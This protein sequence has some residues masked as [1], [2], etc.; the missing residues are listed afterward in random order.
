MLI[1]ES[2]RSSTFFNEFSAIMSENP[3]TVVAFLKL[4][5]KQLY[6]PLLRERSE[7]L[8]I[9]RELKSGIFRVLNLT[10]SETPAYNQEV[11]PRNQRKYC[12]IC[13]PKLKR[14]TVSQR[15][16][17]EGH[18]LSRRGGERRI[19]V[20]HTHTFINKLGVFQSRPSHRRSVGR[21]SAIDH[22]KQATTAHSVT[23]KSEISDWPGQSHRYYCSD[24]AGTAILIQRACKRVSDIRLSIQLCILCALPCVC[25]P[26]MRY[27]RTCTAL[28]IIQ[29]NIRS[30]K[31]CHTSTRPTLDTVE[32]DSQEEKFVR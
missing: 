19:R 32:Y 6:E 21:L 14:E 15:R 27:E 18:G 20:A 5:A 26:R 25:Q 22:P 24:W 13:D 9:S 29:F 17:E 12:S 4:L 16:F 2:Q 23:G 11:L 7:N 1:E 3:K 28:L 10:S 8:H 31:G 30:F